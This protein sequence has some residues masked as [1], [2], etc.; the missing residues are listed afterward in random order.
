[1]DGTVPLFLLL[2]ALIVLSALI[3]CFLADGLERH[4]RLCRQLAD[5]RKQEHASTVDRVVEDCQLV[6]FCIEK[7]SSPGGPDC[8]EQAM[9]ALKECRSD[10]PMDLRRERDAVR[11]GA[12][13]VASEP[14]R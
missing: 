6:E 10:A 12:G 2:A 7:A 13:A 8:V 3:L 1:M 11:A 5:H 14:R 9:R 4:A